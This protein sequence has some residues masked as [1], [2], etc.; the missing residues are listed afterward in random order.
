LETDAQKAEEARLYL[1]RVSDSVVAA[2][3]YLGVPTGTIS[4]IVDDPDFIAIVKTYAVIEPILN[5]LIGTH[6]TAQRLGN[7]EP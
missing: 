5:D 6:G 2:E 7:A 4:S 3:Q 1:A